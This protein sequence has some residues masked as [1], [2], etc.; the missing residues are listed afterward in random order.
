MSSE[1][2]SALEVEIEALK[3]IYIHELDV[4]RTDS[5]G[6]SVKVSLHPATADNADEQYVRLDLVF[7]IPAKY[8]D[9]LPEILIRNPR[10]LSDEKI[11]KIQRELQETAEGNVGCPM[12]YQLIEVAKDH[13]TQENVPCCQCT[14][15]LYGFVEG[16]VFTKTQ[17]Y[18]YFHSH[19]LA[20]Y[21]RHSLEQICREEQ[22]GSKGPPCQEKA[23]TS[24]VL[25]PV[26][27]LP[28][29]LE[30]IADKAYPPPVEMT[31]QPGFS[32]TPELHKLQ[33][34][35]AE[36]YLMQQSRGGIIN[37]DAEKNKFLLEISAAPESSGGGG[38]C[39]PESRKHPNLPRPPGILFTS[40][41]LS[42]AHRLA[43]HCDS[44]ERQQQCSATSAPQRQQMQRKER[45]HRY[46]RPAKAGHMSQSYERRS[47]HAEMT[48][49]SIEP[50]LDGFPDDSIEEDLPEDTER[51]YRMQKQFGRG[52]W[53][54][55]RI[56][57]QGRCT[58]RKDDSAN[59]SHG[60][61]R[62]KHCDW[63][64][65]SSRSYGDTLSRD[66]YDVEQ[67]LRDELPSNQHPKTMHE[68]GGVKSPRSK[69]ANR[70]RKPFGSHVDRQRRSDIASASNDLCVETLQDNRNMVPECH[71]RQS[72]C[73]PYRHNAYRHSNRR[74]A[75]GPRSYGRRR[76]D[77]R[78]AH[79]HAAPES[80][81]GT[82][83]R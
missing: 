55:G 40:E 36:L 83:S 60:L 30:D 46:R 56:F 45:R 49:G 71:N 73:D 82:E 58:G 5:R 69:M 10:G 18:H 24:Q 9:V 26:C 70:P 76:D 20:R 48:N 23:T 32:M 37:V 66:T 25:C 74:G 3:A 38:G 27:R 64:G 53:Q 50:S 61:E 80:C 63:N 67:Q 44:E 13:L 78:T 72:D 77:A 31:K 62:N 81:H 11:E 47:P 54:Q 51:R 28:A 52:S 16:D 65:V 57:K 43:G 35:M 39:T 42:A 34:E 75:S 15:C 8:P 59:Q 17:C 41:A 14:I 1:E 4:D 29:P 6:T 33:Q 12:L 79:G 2:E 7:N 19:C 68:D 22:E 21:V